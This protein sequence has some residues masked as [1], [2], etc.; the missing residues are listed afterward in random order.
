M[1]TLVRVQDFLT[2]TKDVAPVWRINP[3][4]GTLD[5]RAGLSWTG[6]RPYRTATGLVRVLRRFEQVNSEGHRRTLHRLPNAEGHPAGDVNIDPTNFEALTVGFTGDAIDIEPLKGYLRPVGNTSVFR[7]STIANMADDETWREYTELFPAI[8]STVQRVPGTKPK[9]GTSL[10]YNALW[11]GPHIDSEIVSERDD[12]A[13]VGEWMGPNGPE[14]YDI[15]HIVDPNC[16]IVQQLVREAGFKPE[17]LGGNHFAVA[18]QALGGRG[19]EQAEMMRIVDSRS[20]PITSD[21]SRNLTRVALQVNRVRSETDVDPITTGDS[22]VPAPT[23]APEIL[24]PEV[25]PQKVSPMNKQALQFGLGRD[26]A[27]ALDKLGIK[28]PQDLVLHLDEV[29]ATK[30]EAKLAEMQGIFADLIEIVGAAKGDAE[31]MKAKMAD[32]VPAAEAQAAVDKIKEQLAAAEAALAASKE[33][34]SKATADAEASKTKVA[35][36]TA[37]LA[38]LLAEQFKQLCA[39]AI[40]AGYDAPKVEA[41]KDAAE[42]RRHVVLTHPKLG[43]VKYGKANDDVIAAAFDGVWA[44]RPAVALVPDPKVVKSTNDADRVSSLAGL[45]LVTTAAQRVNDAAEQ[46]VKVSTAEEMDG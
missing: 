7:P 45:P 12:G 34:E 36:I 9:T 8:A 25:A 43:E 2:L 5:A 17:L 26:N 29:D 28:V 42:L 15:E 13:L 14:Q 41:C 31:G 39:D 44:A 19:A 18:L 21:Q 23:V 22:A 33:A 1:P 16:D 32:T 6:I 37:D 10:G 3:R 35:E 11:W 27:R 20:L 4:T 40:A 38:P 24:T 46:P 30:L